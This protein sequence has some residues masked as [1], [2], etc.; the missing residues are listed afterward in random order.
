MEKWVEGIFVQKQIGECVCVG[1]I[2][3]MRL[4]SVSPRSLA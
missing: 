4:T 2:G 1:K 3:L